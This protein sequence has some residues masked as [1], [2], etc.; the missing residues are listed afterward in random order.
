MVEVIGSSPIEPTVGFVLN[1]LVVRRVEI[2][3][4]V[5]ISSG[6]TRSVKER[7]EDSRSRRG[8]VEALL[9]S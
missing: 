5:R 3:E 6:G 8:R 2:L 7:G 9:K 4:Q 1:N